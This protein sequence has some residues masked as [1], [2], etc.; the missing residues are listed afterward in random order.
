M[1]KDQN[2]KLILFIVILLSISIYS[3][4]SEIGIILVKLGFHHN[5]SLYENILLFIK[6][7]SSM[8]TVFILFI[9][10]KNKKVTKFI[11]GN[12]YIAGKYKAK[13]ERLDEKD[14]PKSTHSEFFIIKQSLFETI[15]EGYSINEKGKNYANW[16][17][18]LIDIKNNNY[19]FSMIT[20]T[21]KIEPNLDILLLIFSDTEINGKL[22][23]SSS[24]SFGTWRFY[25]TKVA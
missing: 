9:T 4:I 17:G 20:H 3:L 11:L 7:I 6:I 16:N 14:N 13:S 24:N 10:T 12:N 21:N 23:A 2:I 25:V 22:I 19:T 1:I 8:I 5:P 15:I 18:N